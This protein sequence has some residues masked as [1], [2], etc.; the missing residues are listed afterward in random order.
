LNLKKF[1]V[2]SISLH[3]II[4]IGVHFIPHDKIKE[5]KE[6]ITKLV[7]PEELKKPELIPLPPKPRIKLPKPSMVRPK[8]PKFQ[9]PS[10]PRTVTRHPELFPKERLVPGEVKESG[11]SSPEPDKKFGKP[12][13][14]ETGTAKLSQ[15]KPLE[16][17]GFLDTRKLLD[18]GVTDQ[19]ARKGM[20]EKKTR[21]KP[22][23]FDTSE[24]K[25]KGYMNLLRQKL[26]G[27]GCWVYPPDAAVHGIYGDLR[28]RFT[29]KKNGQLGAVELVR[30]SG[31]RDL[32]EAALNALRDCG[33]Y[34]PLPDE[35]GMEAY[36]IEGHFVYSLYGYYVR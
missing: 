5:R 36:T 6:F 20:S 8:P 33:P 13:G 14:E 27:S 16:R 32:D 24:Y 4:L 18:K 3:I 19:I 30:T 29:I 31:Y 2:F 17:P 25:Y 1:L 9:P 12:E 11:K 35:W 34:W 10:A 23:T 21:D 28:V 22:I 26:E 15:S 7:S